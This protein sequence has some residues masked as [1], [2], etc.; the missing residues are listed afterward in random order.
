MN[1]FNEFVVTLEYEKKIDVLHVVFIRPTI[2]A[3]GAESAV[4]SKN[5]P[6]PFPRNV[7]RNQNFSPKARLHTR[8]DSAPLIIAISD[9]ERKITR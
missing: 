9:H 1:T 8:L 4:I 2:I 3:R 5:F 6:Q 7:L